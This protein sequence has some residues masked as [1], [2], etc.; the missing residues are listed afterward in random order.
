MRWPAISK[1]CND[2]GNGCSQYE[3]DGTRINSFRM[4][5]LKSFFESK[6]LKQQ[7]SVETRLRF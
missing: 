7:G 6:F 1:A 5:F 3:R 4:G 2:A